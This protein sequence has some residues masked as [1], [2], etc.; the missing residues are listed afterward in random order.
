ME[1]ARINKY[2]TISEYGVYTCLSCGGKGTY[3][4]MSIKHKEG[5]QFAK[6]GRTPLPREQRYSNKNNLKLKGSKHEANSKKVTTTI[7]NSVNAN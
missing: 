3:L 5:C 4:R 2:Y 6:Q 1:K 7:C